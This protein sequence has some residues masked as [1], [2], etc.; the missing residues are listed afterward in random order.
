MKVDLVAL[1]RGDLQLELITESDLEY[2]LLEAMWRAKRHDENF[3][4]GYG[5][6]IA[7]AGGASGFYITLCCLRP[8]WEPEKARER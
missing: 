5:R 4:R 2:S 1:E 8:A 6:S 3:S 7:P